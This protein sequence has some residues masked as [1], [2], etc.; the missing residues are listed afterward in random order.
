LPDR[1]LVD[2]RLVGLRGARILT[3]RAHTGPS[4]A[5]NT[6]VEASPQRWQRHTIPIQTLAFLTFLQEALANLSPVPYL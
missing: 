5:S 3:Q 4:A 6:T 1:R 2:L